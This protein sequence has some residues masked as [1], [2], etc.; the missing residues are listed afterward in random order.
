MIFLQ[1]KNELDWF[2]E[3]K[4]TTSSHADSFMLTANEL[5]FHQS[6]K[7]QTVL[8]IVFDINLERKS[9]V[10]LASGGKLSFDMPWDPDQWT[11]SPSA[12]AATRNI[13]SI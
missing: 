9:S 6:Q 4:G 8:A 3:V 7:G 2:I 12:Y 5:E 11:F 13:K 1:K 10:P